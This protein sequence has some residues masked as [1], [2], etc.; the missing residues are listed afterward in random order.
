M[1]RSE[2][3][4]K[5]AKETKDKKLLQAQRQEAQLQYEAQVRDILGPERYVEYQRAQHPDYQQVRKVVRR[6]G[7]PS[8][9]AAT[10][11][12]LRQTAQQ[13]ARQLRENTGLEAS[14]RRAALEAIQRETEQTLRQ[15]L[16]EPAFETYRRYGGAWMG[17]MAGGLK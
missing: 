9:L 17:E 8:E 13:S 2:T 4:D 5:L 11:D 10:V 3:Q 14:A 15:T 12:D 6:Y 16:G 7:L 1:A